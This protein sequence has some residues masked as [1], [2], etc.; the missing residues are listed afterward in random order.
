[1]LAANGR[2]ATTPLAPPT[3]AVTTISL[4]RPT[5]TSGGLLMTGKAPVK[6]EIQEWRRLYRTEL[7]F[8][9]F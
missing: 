5:L 7:N 8:S 1:M 2:A 6:G 4:R 3:A 9:K